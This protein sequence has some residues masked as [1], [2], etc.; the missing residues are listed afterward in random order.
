MF[1][2]RVSFNTV[3]KNHKPIKNKLNTCNPSRLEFSNKSPVEDKEK[4]EI[5]QKKP[6]SMDKAVH[7]LPD[8]MLGRM[9]D[10]QNDQSAEKLQRKDDDQQEGIEMMIKYI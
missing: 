7:S 2:L 4:A 6:Q 5:S 9:L 1:Y 3:Y 10:V 8:E